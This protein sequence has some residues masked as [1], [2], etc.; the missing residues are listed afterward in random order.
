MHMERILVCV[1]AQRGAWEALDR[2]FN[3][4]ERLSAHVSV[5][6]IYPEQWVENV[7]SDE[8]ESV[9]ER[10][11]LMLEDAESKGIFVEFYVCRGSYEEEVISF[12]EEHGITHLIVE[13][14]DEGYKESVK[15]LKA[16][17][18]IRHRVQCR[19]EIV[20]KRT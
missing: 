8:E 15:C 10:L 18:N 12:V 16:H 7:A 4:A 17:Q 11:E 6:L 3:L 13:Q 14:A 9:R 2:A 1:E 20:Q 19:I 5:L